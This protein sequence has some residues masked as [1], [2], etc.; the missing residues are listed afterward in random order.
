MWMLL[1]RFSICIFEKRFDRSILDRSNSDESTAP[2]LEI[3][4]LEYMETICSV[5]VVPLETASDDPF[6]RDQRHVQ[7]GS[8]I[9]QRSEH[10]FE[11]ITVRVN[12]DHLKVE[13]TD[14]PTK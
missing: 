9:R 13:T 14:D 1:L 2:L 4:V 10:P 12:L 5:R 7:I 8:S 6:K 3:H 11:R